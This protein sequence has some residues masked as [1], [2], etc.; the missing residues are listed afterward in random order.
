MED[1]AL[2]IFGLVLPLAEMY[3]RFTCNA[4]CPRHVLITWCQAKRLTSAKFLT[5]CLSVILLFRV[6]K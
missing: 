2:G 1:Q 5:N 4:R 6:K 3:A